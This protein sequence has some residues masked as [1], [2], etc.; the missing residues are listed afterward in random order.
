[1]HSDNY[2]DMGEVFF[3][4]CKTVDSP[5]SLGAWLRYKYSHT[6]L[7]SME[8][9]PRDYTEARVFQADYMVSS[10]LSKYKGLDTG[11][12]LE[13]AALQKFTSSEEACAETN[14]RFRNLATIRSGWL[15]RVHHVAQRKIASLLGPF[16][17]FCVDR[18]YGWGPGATLDISR[19][20]SCVD[21]KMCQLPITV[22]RSCKSMLRHEIESDLHWSAAIL[23]SVPEGEFS[24]LDSCFELAES[25]RIATVPKNAK[26]NRVIAIEPRG[27]AFLQKGFGSYF[28]HRLRKVG[29]DLDDQTV[30][31][32]LASSA[33]R[34]GLATLDLRAASDT[35]SKEVVYSLL[36]YDWAASLDAVRTRRAE[37]PDGSSIVLEK[38][39][40]MGN[41]FTFELES[42]I[43][44]S[45][46][47][48]VMDV[49]NKYGAWAVYGDDLIIDRSISTDVCL[50]LQF[51]GFTVN[52]QKSFF[53][54]EFFESCGKHYFSG[55]E[56]TPV[57]Q[58]E[59]ASD[60]S[61]AIRR[62]NRL[63]RA[64]SRFGPHLDSRFKPA[65]ECATR[66]LPSGLSIPFGDEG[67][68]GVLRILGDPLLPPLYSPYP[69]GR[70]GFEGQ[71]FGVL[72]HGTR[73]FVADDRSLL[74]F[75]LR[76]QPFTG[77]RI[78]RLPQGVFRV[79]WEESV[80]Y[81]GSVDFPSQRVTAT[82]RRVIPS[83][84]AARVWR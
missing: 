70:R 34:L 14:K 29:V 47:Q 65:W 39:S 31:Q 24:L 73:S 9:N 62:A 76:T 40:S 36:P 44:W 80:S 58:K 37:M 69:G 12:D 42:L 51:F 32:R 21:T 2:S 27:N 11:V 6:E 5:V 19:R 22:S 78:L 77:W 54:G 71:S 64:S 45:V 57:Y 15:H 46:L 13:A 84:E 48:G 41:G 74:A 3:A 26:T 68:D 83:L 59:V 25:S 67:D 81:A 50:A 52:D 66:G 55:I 17:L 61:E 18:R 49:N 33:N 10:Y 53:D 56:V 23:G 30:N 16:S 43:F 72:K 79:R 60:L 7:A 63:I 38:F 82:R 20:A 1:M 28:R 8:L 75:A 4:L 35:I